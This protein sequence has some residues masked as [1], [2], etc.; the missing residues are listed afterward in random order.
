MPVRKAQARLRFPDGTRKVRGVVMLGSDLP[1]GSHRES[2]LVHKSTAFPCCATASIT[3]SDRHFSPLA[4]GCDVVSPHRITGF[5]AIRAVKVI[6]L[7]KSPPVMPQEPSFLPCCMALCGERA[8]IVGQRQ[9]EKDF[10]HASRLTGNNLRTRFYQN[11]QSVR[12]Y[13]R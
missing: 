8:V 7:C 10:R 11:L 9:Q 12:L 4:Q 6:Q 3:T 13:L 5:R 2:I 1:S